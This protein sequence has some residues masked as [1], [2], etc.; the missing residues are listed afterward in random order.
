M[1][2]PRLS[3]VLKAGL[4][5]TVIVCSGTASPQDQYLTKSVTNGVFTWNINSGVVQLCTG[6]VC[7]PPEN[8][9]PAVPFDAELIMLPNG[10]LWIVTDDAR[11]Q[12]FCSIEPTCSPPRNPLAQA[13]QGAH[14]RYRA[15]ENSHLSAV[16]AGSSRA[17]SCSDEPNCAP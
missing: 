15:T 10:G 13:T 14:Y 4:L 9:A 1:K 2:Y 8:A 17:S 3:G 16:R 6:E 7:A 12:I 5:L 11:Y